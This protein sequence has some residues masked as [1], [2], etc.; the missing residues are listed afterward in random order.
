MAQSPTRS[1]ENA[2]ANL[3]C[4][5]RRRGKPMSL[6]HFP[7]R[8][9][10]RIC[11]LALLVLLVL[12]AACG[13]SSTPQAKKNAP[14]PT[15][16]QGQGQRLLT[17]TAQKFD[18]ARTL[19]GTFTIKI[20]GQ[21]V[22]GSATSE[23]WNAQPNK[24]RTVAQQSTIPQ[25]PAGDVTVNNGK[26]L[27][28]YDPAHK[29]VYTGPVSSSSSS[30]SLSDLL[31]NSGS[32][33]GGVAIVSLIRSIFTDSDATLVS[34]SASVNGQPAYDIH[35]V[36]KNGSSKHESSTSTGFGNFSYSGEVYIDK[37]T[38][39]PG[40][41]VL[42]I[43]DVGQVEIDI[44]SLVLNQPIAASTFTFV[45][46]SGVKVLSLQQQSSSSASGSALSLSQAQQQAGYHL[47]SIPSSQTGYTLQGVNAL[48][49]P[50]NQV[51]T[52][53]YTTSTTPGKAFTLAEG[54]AL[55]NLPVSGGRKVSI[56][57][58]TGMLATSG[59][60][61]TLTWT[62]KGVGI[63]ITGSGLSSAQAETIAKLLI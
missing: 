43:Q 62:E 58:T 17:Q 23:V 42:L 3:K 6:Q 5:E 25:F 51:Y 21:T 9:E 46:P 31:P 40:Q 59:G 33:S 41:V 35:V 39:L 13:G 19:H 34:S 36:S 22:N 32:G 57:G 14:L 2:L 44:A 20:T 8:A 54:K 48:G 27:W 18:S 50:G 7:G 30:S 1:R 56:R 29:V 15:P 63:T 49:A 38:M 11:A 55:A 53:S 28:Q 16:T 26:Q 37:A 12:L 61:T 4:S 47:L 60:S 10:S 52:L 24:S 45:V